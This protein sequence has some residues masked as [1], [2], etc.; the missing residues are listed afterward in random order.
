MKGSGYYLTA[1]QKRHYQVPENQRINALDP[2]IRTLITLGFFCVLWRLH[3]YSDL[4]TI[5]STE[6]N[7]SHLITGVIL[8]GGR[9]TRMDGKDKGLIRLRE[10]YLIEHVITALRPQ[11]DSLFINA[12]RNHERYRQL[13]NLPIIP[14]LIADYPGPLAGIATGLHHATTEHVVFTPCDSPLIPHDL[15]ARLYQ[16]MQQQQA[17]IS[18][19]MIDGCLQPVFAL[20]QRHLLVE[21]LGFLHSGQR[22]VEVWYQQY[23][24]ATIDCSDQAAN[25]V[26]LNSPTE[27]AQLDSAKTV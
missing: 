20:I 12:N 1:P 21:L 3:P 9:A 23:P 10:H 5:A 18:T 25:F 16:A 26:N 8:A 11:V 4:L 2:G 22:K 13:T 7:M 17:A 27:L 6:K 15:V 19:V 24:L 14:D